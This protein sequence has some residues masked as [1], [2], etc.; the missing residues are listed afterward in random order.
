MFTF[1]WQRRDALA[2]EQRARAAV[3]TARASESLAK[4]LLLDQRPDVCN[5]DEQ[6]GEEPGPSA[7]VASAAWRRTQDDLLT[8][9]DVA[10]LDIADIDLRSRLDEVGQ[11]FRYH[12]GPQH[13]I[14]QSEYRTRYIAVRHALACIGA[15][16]RGDALPARSKEYVNTHEY[17][18]IYLDM[19]EANSTRS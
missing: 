12:E 19:L 4:L 9:V 17:V 5:E 14:R 15:F 18:T 11:I 3:A 16:R 6:R 8:S 10:A 13:Y 1:R 2:A 7:E